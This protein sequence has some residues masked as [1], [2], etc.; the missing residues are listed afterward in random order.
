MSAPRSFDL[1]A[2][3]I[4]QSDY[5]RRS[6]AS[7]G[8][9][10]GHKEWSH[11]CVFG[12]PV[13][14]LVNV[15]LMDEPRGGVARVETPRLTLLARDSDGWDGDVR[16]F[17][18]NS[19]RLVGGGVDID[20]AGNRIAFDDGIYELEA[21]LPERDL[22]VR[23]RFLPKARSALTSSS[24]LAPAGGIKWFVL[25]RLEAEGEIRLR[26]RRHRLRR[27]LAY[28]DRDWGRFVWG[29]D[30][31]WEWAIVLPSDPR[32]PWSVVFQRITDRA[33]LRAV[34]QSVLLWRASA[35][36]RTWQSDEIAVRPAGLLR[37]RH[38]LRVPRVMSLVAPGHATGLPKRLD[39]DATS[40]RDELRLRF[41]L[42]DYAQIAIPNDD[43]PGV[44]LL[45]EVRAQARVEGTVRGEPIG[46]DGAAFME[47]NH[48]PT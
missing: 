26:G 21:R 22:E 2:A 38:S 16:S 1:G 47:W 43:G 12:P 8:G 45:S 6:P 28:H 14:L 41:E 11:F 3:L 42:E 4:R 7:A 44:T 20:V 23:L 10:A 46:F 29:G 17:R 48:A 27:A 37:R 34:S 19:A 40:G 33:R 25:P 30:F 32:V 31:A 5:W 36:A 35:Y 18:P 24:R 39:V 13:D 9:R 15:S